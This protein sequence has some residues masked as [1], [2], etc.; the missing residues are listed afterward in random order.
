MKLIGQLLMKKKKKWNDKAI[1]L[2]KSGMGEA[3]IK[4]LIKCMTDPDYLFSNRTDL[5]KD[6]NDI[7]GTNFNSS[8]TNM[9]K[10]LSSDEE[11][12]KLVS[13]DDLCISFAKSKYLYE[14]FEEDSIRIK[15]Q[16][17]FKNN[18]DIF[19]AVFNNNITTQYLSKSNYNKG[20][21]IINAIPQ[22][23]GTTNTILNNYELLF[24][25][26]NNMWV[27]Y[28]NKIIE[29]DDDTIIYNYNNHFRAQ[30]EYLLIKRPDL[31]TSLLALNNDN[32]NNF[33]NAF[34]YDSGFKY[35]RY[36]L[37]EAFSNDDFIKLLINNKDDYHDL[38]SNAAINDNTQ[39]LKKILYNHIN[40]YKLFNKTVVMENNLSALNEKCKIDN[41]IIFIE[42]LN[43]NNTK[44]K[45]K[46]KNNVIAFIDSGFRD[47]S[48]D[49]RQE[50]V[51]FSGVSFSGCTFEANGDAKVL[52]EIYTPKQ[53]NKYSTH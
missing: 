21:E 7:Y 28:M 18:F 49:N 40:F 47:F 50:I 51:N 30:F 13:N 35:D 1:E 25:M 45:V 20:Y 43:N 2:D 36:C 44:V 24:G 26:T 23:T 11:T 5:Y 6:L 4:K 31:F 39:S 48:K 10:L 27:Y 22:S 46:H 16:E 8:T 37:S 17:R 15:I 19:E 32:F 33:A 41:S 42:V 38:F 34:L 12:S 52:C 29:H 53:T 3:R 14:F 9:Y